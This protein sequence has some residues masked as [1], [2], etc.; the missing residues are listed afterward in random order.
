MKPFQIQA[1]SVRPLTSVAFC[2]LLFLAAA[3]GPTRADETYTYTGKPLL[4]LSGEPCRSGC[5]VTGSF[6]VAQP[7]APDLYYA[8]ITPLAAD[9]TAGPISFDLFGVIYTVDPNFNSGVFYAFSTNR[10]GAI[11]TWGIDLRSGRQA[12]LFCWVILDELLRLSFSWHKSRAGTM[13]RALVRAP[14]HPRRH[15]PRNQRACCFSALACWCS[16]A[17]RGRRTRKSVC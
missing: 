7:L 13:R 14:G 15:P 1:R 6:T 11:T 16:W 12:G 3:A 10:A 5:T 17:R 4:N 9:F 2:G 8:H